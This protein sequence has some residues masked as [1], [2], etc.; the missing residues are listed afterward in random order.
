M[1]KPI[2]AKEC[3]PVRRLHAALLK[4]GNM[5]AFPNSAHLPASNGSNVSSARYGAGLDSIRHWKEV[6]GVR[7]RQTSYVSEGTVVAN[8]ILRVECRTHNNQCCLRTNLISPVSDHCRGGFRE[9]MDRN[10]PTLLKAARVPQKQ[11]IRA[12]SLPER[13]FPNA[14]FN[15]G[16]KAN[17]QPT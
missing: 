4:D 11:H 7:V 3:R 1:L 16:Q 15:T 6:P 10:V 14:G 17:N 9:N 5:I 2:L 8:G 13:I 12:P